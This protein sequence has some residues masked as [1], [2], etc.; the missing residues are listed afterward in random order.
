[1]VDLP[2][3]IHSAAQMRAIDAFAAER[4]GIPTYELMSRAGAGAFA[5]LQRAWPAARRIVVLCGTG[6]NG[7]DGYV[8]AR[9]ARAAGLDVHVVSSGDTQR[10]QGDAARAY[11]DFVAEG[12]QSVRNFSVEFARYDVIVD[13][14]FGTGIARAIVG[15]IATLIAQANDSQ[16]PIL[17]LDLPSG[18]DADT[19]AVQGTA[20]RAHRTITFAGLKLGFFLGQG[21]D[22]VGVIEVCDLGMP[23]VAYEHVGA[24]AARIAE[25]EIPALL[26]R[27]RR[28]THKGDNGRVL[29]VGGGPGMG[30]AAAL[31]GEAALRVGAGLVTLATHANVA[32]GVLSRRPELMVRAIENA[33]EL[34]PLLEA[35]DVVALGPGLGRHAWS[36]QM[37]AAV[38]RSAK[39]LVLDADGLNLLAENPFLRRDWILTPHPGEAARLLGCSTADIQADRLGAA[40]MLSAKFEAIVVLKGAASLVQVPQEMPAVCLAGNPGMATAGMGDVLTGVIAGIAAQSGNLSKSARVGVLAHAMAGD[41]AARAGERGLIASDL[42]EHL[43]ACLNP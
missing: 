6:N 24:V 37:F 18:L 11:N 28:S 31:A 23:A 1:M 22:H 36:S 12:G 32:A 30:G 40:R 27:R 21:P 16:V 43:R 29:V 5:A 33:T 35:A 20:I 10:L 7:G 3:T 19:G 2:L 42:F 41:R 34:E 13:G 8:V 17:A 4:A 39:P 25:G 38:V 14:L 26:G 9:L 15:D